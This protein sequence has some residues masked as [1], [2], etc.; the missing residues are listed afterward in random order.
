MT[1]DTCSPESYFQAA[2]Q[3]FEWAEQKA[4]GA[5]D[6]SCVIGGLAV[7]LRFAGPAL[8]AQL[9]P[10]LAHLATPPA[11][12]PAL[13]VHLWDSVSTGVEM[14]PP[15]W[16]EDAYQARMEVRGFGDDSAIGVAYDLGAGALSMLDMKRDWALYWT[17]DAR[18]LPG[19]EAGA[20]LRTILHLWMGHQGRRFVHAAAVGTADGGV[21]LAGK[22]GAG[23]STAALACLDAGLLYGGDD[24]CLL[25]TGPAPYL[26]SLYNS[27]KLD[28]HNGQGLSLVTPLAG[29]ARRIET[30]KVLFFL[31]QHCPEQMVRGFP[32]QA[33][34]VSQITGRPNTA[35]APA[36]PAVALKP[37]AASTILQL[38][39]S[40]QAAL[41]DLARLVQQVPCYHLHLG[42]DLTTIP[43][44]IRDL[45]G[46]M[47]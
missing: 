43:A 25:E 38:P 3:A 2:H 42:T 23:K 41:R 1:T 36:A 10:A 34:L 35:L 20:P 44:A 14:P 40:G 16:P 6:H 12:A 24:Y 8:V 37:L 32:L 47:A 9:T 30:G 11:P 7:H 15:P 4:G 28:T 39:G 19:Y 18:R 33:I 45:L 46:S 5:V 29:S 31:Q 27:A 26:H 17:H 21:L 22:G 13:T